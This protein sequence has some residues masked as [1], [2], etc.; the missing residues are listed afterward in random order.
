MQSNK[1]LILSLIFFAI[2][3]FA[4]LPGTWE[5]FGEANN[6]RCIISHNG[7]VYIGTHGGVVSFTPGAENERIMT[8]VHGLGGLVVVAL[9]EHD[10]KLYCASS[11][12]S[13]SR[14]DGNSWS[15][16]TGF[17]RANIGINDLESGGEYLFC[18]TTQGIS[19][20]KPLSGSDP[21]EIKESYSK[22][23]SFPQNSPVKC[24]AVDDSIIWAGLNDGLAMAPL[25]ASLFVP[26]A[27]TT[28][29]FP[30]SVN[31]LFADSGGVWFALQKAE[32]Q[33]SIF[34]TN[35]ST[36]DTVSQTFMFNRA[37]RGFFKADGKL[38]AHGDDGMY[39][40]R[41]RNNFAR[42]MI[43]VITGAYGG[44]KCGDSIYIALRYGHGVISRDTVRS[45]QANAP[46]G[47]GFIDI[48]VAPNGDVWVVSQ[49]A[50]LCRYRNG[51]WRNFNYRTLE[52][53][54]SILAIVDANIHKS[55]VIAIDPDNTVWI[56]TSGAGI[57]RYS[58]DD[59]WEIFDASNSILSGLP[60]S[61]STA[62]CWAM[63]YD[64]DW[65]VMWI[66]NY[67]G[68]NALVCAAFRRGTALTAPLS[69]YYSGTAGLP[70]NYVLGMSA[71]KGRLWLALKD[72]GI[73]MLDLGANLSSHADDHVRKYDSQ[74]P[75]ASAYQISCDVNGNAW[76]AV[77]GGVS[78]IDPILG[79]VTNHALPAHVSLGVG[80]VAVDNWDN[81]W[82]T[83]DKGAAMFRSSD[84]TWHAIRT[85]YSEDADPG[86]RTDLL[87]DLLYA[88][89]VNPLN[90]DIWFAGE[91]GISVF[92]TGFVDPDN[93]IKELVAN[94]NPF[95]WDGMAQ[96]KT[97]IRN[98]PPDADLEI[99]SSDG[100]LVRTIRISERGPSATAR[101]DGRNEHGKPVASGIY[102]LVAKS[103]NYTARG[104]MALIKTK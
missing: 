44:A 81:V 1:K 16:Y 25:D 48:A 30:R 55:K 70:N 14:L 86:E 3:A 64:S 62:V 63:A 17:L 61:P 5:T 94:P 83:T 84:S 46:F 69:S 8:N 13:V 11:N 2:S 20:L 15:S 91:G 22:L 52:P 87:T 90:G 92:H 98:V 78:S 74:L 45:R 79:I 29:S 47:S 93:A 37:I 26:D 53:T 10:N 12:G 56:G 72:E 27:W 97:I 68:A 42:V 21:V 77:E 99:F 65:D 71:S 50:G 60:G 33:P 59:R 51:V 18:A 39:V 7:K 28:R 4:Q 24:L 76:I 104:K 54:D 66:T 43:D 57:F 85:R 88:V 75:S 36:I 67:D 82:V 23:G 73:T 31:A 34:W 100:S 49:I 38:Y 35:G 40:M 32:G 103:K 6:C 95:I 101:W 96:A 41:S 102:I 19:K 58:T 9:A 89:A 80:D